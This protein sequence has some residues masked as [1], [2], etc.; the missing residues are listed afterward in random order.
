ME[1][2]TFLSIFLGFS[3][4][5]SIR[6]PIEDNMTASTPMVDNTAIT[7]PT[8]INVASS[9]ISL[10]SI[11]INATSAAINMT[12]TEFNVTSTEISATTSDVAPVPRDCCCH[13]EEY[14]HCDKSCQA[15]VIFALLSVL[16]AAWLQANGGIGRK[17]KRSLPSRQQRMLDPE[18]MSDWDTQLDRFYAEVVERAKFKGTQ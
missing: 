14:H 15:F 8:K 10:T 11:G 2:S 4:L 9:D 12:S 18:W 1:L 13:K 3:N 5:T 6:A 7:T 16:L 17:R